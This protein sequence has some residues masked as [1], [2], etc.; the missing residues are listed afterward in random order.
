ME[1]GAFGA[2]VGSIRLVLSMS[3]F[4]DA[5][6]LP[7]VDVKSFPPGKPP[8]TYFLRA[9]RDELE[10]FAVAF[11]AVGFELLLCDLDIMVAVESAT[12]ASGLRADSEPVILRL[13]TSPCHVDAC[14]LGFL[15]VLEFPAKHLF[16]AGRGSY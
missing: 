8:L 16:S 5:R 3:V 10:S 2:L 12:E 15:S 14:H 7:S 11:L 13:I 1:A 9:P 6:W 4:A